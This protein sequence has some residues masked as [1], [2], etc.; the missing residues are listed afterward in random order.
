MLENLTT[1][2]NGIIIDTVIGGNEDTFFID[3]INY[4]WELTVANMGE[5]EVE[6]YNIGST[7]YGW[8]GIIEFISEEGLLQGE[9][10]THNGD[11]SFS[12]SAFPFTTIKAWV[13]SD[14]LDSN[15]ENNTLQTSLA[16][17]TEDVFELDV[18]LY[19]NPVSNIL[20]TN[21]EGSFSYKIFNGNGVCIENKQDHL[22]SGIDVS[23]LAQ[24][25][26]ILEILT[27]EGRVN[28]R[29]VKM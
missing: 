6:S 3:R 13:G 19:P 26:Y 22:F 17:N 27:Q 11:F 21:L 1:V 16:T 8:Q 24:G 14:H 7:K 9:T 2:Y 18:L 5:K 4:S 15:C 28:K 25:M 29:F 10:R 23:A 20:S 12:E